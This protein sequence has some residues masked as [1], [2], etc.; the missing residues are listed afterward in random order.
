MLLNM[1]CCVET[2]AGK[3]GGSSQIYT[4]NMHTKQINISTNSIKKG[5]RNNNS[6]K[7][8]YIIKNFKFLYQKQ[9]RYH[10]FIPVTARRA[11]K[12][13]I[14][15]RTKDMPKYPVREKRNA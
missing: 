2:V 4:R 8:S 14:K 1:L 15:A 10:L 6:Q 7:L 12:I 5:Q 11:P 3:G 9:H 13:L